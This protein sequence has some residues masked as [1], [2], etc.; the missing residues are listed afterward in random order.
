VTAY[1]VAVTLPVTEND[2]LAHIAARSAAMKGR[3]TIPPGDD[4]GA[5]RVT[6]GDL[7]VTVDQVIDGV[8]VDSATQPLPLIARKAITRN[9]SDV[10]AM[11]AL[12]VGA[13]AA[14]CVPRTWSAERGRQLSDALR[15]VADAYACP[16][17]G[18][19][20]TIWGGPLVLSVTVLA[21]PA[22]IT[23]VPRRG[24]RP[25]DAI[26]V[27]GVLGN[28]L[29]SGHH[30]TFEPRLQLARTLAGNPATRPTTMMDLSDGLAMD[31]P[32][33]TDHAFIDADALPVRDGTPA[34][35]W[36]HAVGDGEDYE[37]LFTASAGA[38]MPTT[39]GGVR[40]TRVGEVSNAG[41]V[42]FVDTAGRLLDASG[43]GWEHGRC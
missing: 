36:R 29:S 32:R 7:L 25:G 16:L 33:M 14:A 28:S 12:P 6:A 13:V 35:R 38:S 8:H 42:R 30:L 39:I 40:V 41:G 17:F 31:L 15:E 37:L 27:T 34:P 11:A 21:E 22:G 2:L 10:A 5:V 26:Y 19:D 3:V 24:A 18:G 1:A 20:I 4:M 43:L 23:P 9:L